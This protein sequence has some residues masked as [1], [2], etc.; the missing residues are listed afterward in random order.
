[1]AKGVEDTAFYRYLRLLALN[2]VGGDP[3]RFSLAVEDFHARQ[4]RARARASRTRCSPGPTHDTKR[5]GD[6]RARIGALAALAEQWAEHVAALARAQRAAAPR[7]G[8]RPDRGV[9]DLPDARRR[10]ADR[11]PSASP[12]TWT[13]R[14]ARRSATRA[15]PSPTAAGS[16]RS[17]ASPRALLDHEPFLADFEPFAAKVARAGERAALGQLA[18]PAHLPR[19]SRTSTRA[20]SSGT[21]RSSIPTTAAR[22]LG[23]P[24]RLLSRCARRRPADPRD[25][26][27]L[28]D[29]HAL[30]LRAR[31]PAAFDDGTTCR[32]TLRRRC[33]R[34]VAATTC[35]VAIPLEGRRGRLR[36]A[37]WELARGA[38][39]DR[40]VPGWLPAPAS[41]A[42]WL[43]RLCPRIAGT[44]T[45]RSSRADPRREQRA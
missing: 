28:G 16:G 15:G 45:A 36:P 17:H 25:G 11:R 21:S 14:C 35:V 1:M 19:A 41:G 33:A 9:P 43:V 2:E 27:A 3:G 37:G 6:V 10:L 44:R 12:P 31:Q 39:W 29:P 34:S 8:A 30:A 32:S 4:P 22:R 5:S 7:A 18:A 38:A 23:S 20:T 26:E 24:A 13:R 42:A 40:R